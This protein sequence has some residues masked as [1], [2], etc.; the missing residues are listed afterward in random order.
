MYVVLC[1]S[2]S[3]MADMTA[4]ALKLK[5]RGD[6]VLTPQFTIGESPENQE[7]SAS[8]KINGDLIRG[9]FEKIKSCDAVLIVN[10]ER[11]G[12]EGYVGGNSLLEMGFAHVLHKPVYLWNDIPDMGYADE[13]VAMQPVVIHGDL[14]KIQP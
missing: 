4:I 7:G 13:I 12:I 1:G 10:V 14:T 5:A 9:Y 8:H 3:A 6:E 11:K 2:M